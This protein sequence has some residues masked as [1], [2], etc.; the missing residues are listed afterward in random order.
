LIK[1]KRIYDT[2]SHEDGFRILVDRLW[3]RGLSRMRAEIDLWFKEIAPSPQLRRWYGHDP[4]KWKEFKQRYFTELEGKKELVKILLTLEKE[5]EVITLQYSA[6]DEKHNNA[7]A[8]KE[9]L[10]K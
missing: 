3:P 9:Y 6:R 1:V 7:Q 10:R 5:K 4:T 8:L 2:P